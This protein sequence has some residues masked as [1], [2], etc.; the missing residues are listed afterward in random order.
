MGRYFLGGREGLPM[1]TSIDSGKTEALM[2]LL[3]N[4]P[5]FPIKKQTKLKTHIQN[6]NKTLKREVETNNWQ[7]RNHYGHKPHQ[8]EAD[9]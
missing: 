3:W 8:W 6:D 1:I 2:V 4:L 9:T 5:K 7:P